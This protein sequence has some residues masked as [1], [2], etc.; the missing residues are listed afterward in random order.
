MNDR[1]V[2]FKW[3]GF[4][5]TRLLER[6]IKMQ[7]NVPAFYTEQTV[8]DDIINTFIGVAPKM[9]GVSKNITPIEQAPAKKACRKKEET[10][11]CNE[12]PFSLDGERI[13]YLTSQ[14]HTAHWQ[15]EF[16][17]EEKFG[18]REVRPSNI[19][20]AIEWIK[21]GK[22]SL[23]EDEGYGGFWNR[24]RWVQVPKDKK[25]YEKATEALQDLRQSVQDAIF[26]KSSDEAYKALTDFRNWK[27]AG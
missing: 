6:D 18:M 9:K 7:T 10:K 4:C 23:K 19:E 5:F 15:K 8:Y 16:E 20:E 12:T 27:Y 13:E 22:F 24:L 3:I 1:L 25:G 11:M 14:L 26:L 2:Y 17:L 21:A